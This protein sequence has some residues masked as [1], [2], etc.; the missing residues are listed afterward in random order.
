MFQTLPLATRLRR[1]RFAQT[2]KTE[3]L[4]LDTACV[5]VVGSGQKL[6]F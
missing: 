3:V 5:L 2:G 1:G 4:A 6:D